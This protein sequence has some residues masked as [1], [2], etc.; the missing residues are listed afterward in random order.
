MSCNIQQYLIEQYIPAFQRHRHF[1]CKK[2][3]MMNFKYAKNNSPVFFPYKLKVAVGKKPTPQQPQS[4]KF[5]IKVFSVYS[6]FKYLQYENKSDVHKI[7]NINQTTY[8][9]T[10]FMWE[11]NN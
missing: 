9:N 7:S 6:Y 2:S 4:M 3:W 1:L 8:S 5:Y 11:K 10:T